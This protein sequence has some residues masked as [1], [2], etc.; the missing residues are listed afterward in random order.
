MLKNWEFIFVFFL[1]PDASIAAIFSVQNFLSSSGKC[2]YVSDNTVQHPTV[3]FI[4][5]S[6]IFNNYNIILTISCS[7]FVKF[8]R[9]EIVHFFIYLFSLTKE[10]M[11]FHYRN[12]FWYYLS[13][14]WCCN[15]MAMFLLEA[16]GVN[17]KLL[18]RF[19]FWST[20]FSEINCRFGSFHFFYFS[21]ILFYFYFF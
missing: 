15:S 16:W 20:L 9:E 21:F 14:D 1:L 17:G 3:T 2:T 10:G 7:F 12:H 13:L 18:F 6:L 5:G 19:L 11:Y 4:R 8:W